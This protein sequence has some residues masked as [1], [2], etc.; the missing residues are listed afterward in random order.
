LKK[1]DLMEL[2]NRL[3]LP[4]V[5]IYRVATFFKAFS[6]T[7]RG[8]YLI[9]VCLGTACHVRGGDKVLNELER[10]LN[11]KP[12][13][14]TENQKFTLQ[15]VNCLGACALGPVVVVNNKYFGNVIPK[16]VKDI[17]AQYD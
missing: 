3:N 8:K 1:D 5:D 16:K 6:L 12:G 11:I 14:T 17:I 13:E 15:T 4:I 7:P 9:Q 10:N 2:A